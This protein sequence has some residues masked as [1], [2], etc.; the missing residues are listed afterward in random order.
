VHNPNDRP[1]LPAASKF[2]DEVRGLYAEG[3][4]AETLWARVKDAMTPLLADQGLKESSKTWPLTVEDA[5]KV[6]NLLFYE[7][8][9]YGFVFNATVR[10]A[11]S[12]TSIHDHGDVWT[13]YGIIE[14]NETMNRFERTDDGP[15]DE[16]PATL[17]QVGTGKIGPGN[18]DVVPPGKI[19]QERGGATDSMAF[20]VRAQKAGTFKQHSYNAETGEV[21][22][23]HGPALIPYA[24]EPVT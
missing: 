13:L 11:N 10:K 5:P 20:I 19:H 22:V 23:N 18:I 3:L 21:K 9:D 7:D 12:L 17:K 1:T 15:R 14:G 4:D 16:G 6:K 24:L 8:P 2:V